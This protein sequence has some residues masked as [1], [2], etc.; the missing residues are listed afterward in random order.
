MLR[1]SGWVARNAGPSTIRG[2]EAE[3]RA[4]LAMIWENRS[5]RKDQ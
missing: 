3:I 1:R 5:K 4:G 2:L